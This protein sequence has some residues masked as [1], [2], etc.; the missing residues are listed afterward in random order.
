MMPAASRYHIQTRRGTNVRIGPISIIT[1]IAVISLTVL[2][3]LAVSTAHASST[4]AE[5]QAVNTQL[6][7]A[8]ECAGQEF[9]ASID[10]ALAD[11]RA[12]GGN[13]TDG[14]RAIE[15]SL[16][17]ACANARNASDKTVECTASVKGYTVSAEFVCEDTRQLKVEIS[18]LEDATYRIDRWKNTSVQQEEPPA[19]SLWAG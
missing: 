8:N 18:V 9:L 17:K 11:V 16:N 14:I 10:D 7:Y 2:A 3:V 12:K 15:G 5:R 1:L 19:G 4:I 13:A 6:M